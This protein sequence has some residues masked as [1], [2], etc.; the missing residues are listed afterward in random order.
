MHSWS[1]ALQLMILQATR[2]NTPKYVA[3]VR[4]D[5]INCTAFLTQQPLISLVCD[6]APKVCTD[7]TNTDVQHRCQHCLT[8]AV[9]LFLSKTAVVGRLQAPRH[10]EMPARRFEHVRSLYSY[11]S[12]ATSAISAH[13]RNK[14]LHAVAL[15]DNQDQVQVHTAS[16]LGIPQWNCNTTCQCPSMS[17]ARVQ[18]VLTGL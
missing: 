4:Q 14:G 12:G 10:F 9:L 18:M 17:R 6:I 2:H 16:C 5:I 1:R 7:R 8:Y 3:I 13:K 11:T 15:Q